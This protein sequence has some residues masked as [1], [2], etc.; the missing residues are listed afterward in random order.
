MLVIDEKARYHVVFII[1]YW[2]FVIYFVAFPS[3]HWRLHHDS[4][5]KNLVQHTGQ[6]RKEI[7]RQRL[8]NVTSRNK[9]HIS[10]R[11]SELNLF[12]MWCQWSNFTWGECLF[13]RWISQTRCRLER[14]GCHL[15]V[16]KN[17]KELKAQCF[18]KTTTDNNV[19]SLVD[20]A[21]FLTIIHWAR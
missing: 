11:F 13:L 16:S 2:N 9:F 21:D 12:V 5:L 17:W 20:S 1:C 7:S 6:R 14:H 15:Q 10:V 3:L 4:R 18:T 19:R 8:K